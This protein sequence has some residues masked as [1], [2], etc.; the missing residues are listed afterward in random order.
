MFQ[1]ELAFY[2]F[3][4]S[5]DFMLVFRLAP[6]LI[7]GA[8]SSNDLPAVSGGKARFYQTNHRKCLDSTVLFDKALARARHL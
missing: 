8:G 7:V 5:L 6:P 4:F 3:E 1:S 2:P